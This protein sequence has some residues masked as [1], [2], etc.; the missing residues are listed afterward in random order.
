MHSLL[1]IPAY[2]EKMKNAGKIPADAIVFD[3][4]DSIKQEHKSRALYNLV[5]FLKNFDKKEKTI[6]VR[7]NSNEINAEIKA[8]QIVENKIDGLMIPKFEE[9][10]LMKDLRDM[11]K[12][13]IALVET[14]LGLINLK[15]IVTCKEIWALAFGAEDYCCTVNMKNGRDYLLPIK[16]EIVKY[17]NAFNKKCFDTVST[18]IVNQTK[19]LE[20]VQESYC[21]GFN[22]KLAIHPNQINVIKSVFSLEDR[23]KMLDILTAYEKNNNGVLCYEG[24]IYE[25]PHIEKIKKELEKQDE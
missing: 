6:F 10:A 2:E 25:R 7:V 20:E 14:P 24:Q 9:A 3:L 5:H 15:Q 18:A 22:G 17:A 8:L 19:L 21:L 23:Q 12:K 11:N 16:T 4:E 13:I 1:F